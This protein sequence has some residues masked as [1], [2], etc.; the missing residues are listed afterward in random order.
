MLTSTTVNNLATLLGVVREEALGEFQRAAQAKSTEALRAGAFHSSG[1]LLGVDRAA[2]ETM[3]GAAQKVLD[4]ILTAHAAEPTRDTAGRSVQLTA[5]LNQALTDIST[6]LEQERNERL[7]SVQGFAGTL[8]GLSQAATLLR[9]K[10]SARLQMRIAAFNN[11]GQPM[12]TF[13]VNG[14]VGSIQTGHNSTA[15]VTQNVIAPSREEAL[16]ALARIEDL[17]RQSGD[18]QQAKSEVLEV[19]GDLRQQ[20]KRDAPNPLKVSMLLGGLAIVVQTIP[21]LG[22][23]WDVLTRWGAALRDAGSA[24]SGV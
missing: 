1:H 12:N 8:T 24:V 13:N 18:D 7:K 23:A 14:S 22:P 9:A 17:L 3:K 11:T 2:A 20:V 16:Q 19:V 10:C 21:Q 15:N 5:L 6:A 4:E